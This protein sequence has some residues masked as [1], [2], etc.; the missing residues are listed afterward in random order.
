MNLNK[1][2]FIIIIFVFWAFFSLILKSDFTRAKNW[3]HNGVLNVP[4]IFFQK[5]EKVRPILQNIDK[6]TQKSN[7]FLAEK[8]VIN[9]IDT[10]QKILAL[11]F[12]ADMTPGMEYSLRSGIVKSWYNEKLIKE[13]NETQAPATL[14]LTG[15]WIKNYPE[16]T[17]ELAANPLFEI[18]S[19][20][21][22]HP[23]FSLPCFGLKAIPD[24][25][26]EE[27]IAKTDELLK[28]YA[29]NYK[30]YFRFP[31]L[32]YDKFDV[33]AAEK[34]GYKIIHGDVIG[35]DGFTNNAEGIASLVV[36]RAKP[37][38]IIILHMHGHPN[39]PKTADAVPEI[40]RRLKEKG[41]S[42]AKV[43]ELL[44]QN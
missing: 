1:L 8:D 16:T 31:G 15:L 6:I 5:K 41:Y 36:A 23:A 24:S 25:S 37:G 33:A 13:L 11:T 19:H 10:K 35:G 30:K 20:S 34:H 42:F 28:L 4:Q 9:K 3:D 32:C 18:A 27:E 22:S 26:D 7:P 43:S 12:D 44:A 29:P 21:Y 14:F 38:S 2:H 17:K 39:A 40:I